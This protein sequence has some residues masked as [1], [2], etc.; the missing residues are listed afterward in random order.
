MSAYEIVNKTSKKLEKELRKYCG[1]AQGTS[2]QEQINS[3]QYGISSDYEKKFRKLASIRNKLMHD[4]DYELDEEGIR[5]YKKVSEECFDY[6]ASSSHDLETAFTFVMKT[7]KKIES[8]LKND[9]GAEGKGLLQYTN[10]L[11]GKLPDSVIHYLQHIGKVRNTLVH[12][13][14]SYLT[15]KNL[16]EFKLASKEVFSFFESLEE[17][18]IREQEAERER[19]QKRQEHEQLMLEFRERYKEYQKKTSF[20]FW[21][22]ILTLVPFVASIIN[23]KNLVILLVIIFCFFSNRKKIQYLCVSL[24]V[25]LL[26]SL[27]SKFLQ[28]LSLIFDR[29]LIFNLVLFAISIF[30]IKFVYKTKTRPYFKKTIEGIWAGIH[31]LLAALFML[32]VA[33]YFST[34]TLEEFGLWEYEWHALSLITIGFATKI[35]LDSGHYRYNLCFPYFVILAELYTAES[36]FPPGLFF[37]CGILILL[38]ILKKGSSTPATSNEDEDI[39]VLKVSGQ[40]KGI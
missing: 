39:P 12:D 30:A 13:E 22:F 3:I 20:I 24:P 29:S 18:K 1:D 40:I 6:L 16:E 37:G 11:S 25:N 15:T 23:D 34:P 35:I 32:V 10:Y 21:I 36:I 31:P 9:M 5:E 17:H 7:C 4:P 14:D 28:G 19:Q 33:L 8:R 26:F 27:D 2:L 38:A